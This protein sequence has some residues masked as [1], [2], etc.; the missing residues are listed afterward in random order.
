MHPAAQ[1]DANAAEIMLYMYLKRNCYIVDN[2]MLGPP[3]QVDNFKIV[4]TE[5]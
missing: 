1:R 4:L 5:Y 3:R 2:P